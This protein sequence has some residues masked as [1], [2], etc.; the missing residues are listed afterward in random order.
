M[1]VLTILKPLFWVCVCVQA[2][3]PCFCSVYFDT[4]LRPRACVCVCLH[5]CS[6]L[7]VLF[8]FWLLLTPSSDHVHA[9]VCLHL[10]SGS[11]A[12]PSA[13]GF[14]FSSGPAP[15]PGECMPRWVSSVYC[16]FIC[17]LPVWV[18]VCLSMCLCACVCVSVCV[19]V[20]VCVCVC[21]QTCVS[22]YVYICY[23]AVCCNSQHCFKGAGH[24]RPSHL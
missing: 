7:S 17:T 23:C 18:S 4:F 1:H 15:A 21:V 19:R 22:V 16:V 12:A 6:G 9:C 11:S 8:L 20:C 10:C 5:L 2:R 24:A 14:S 3:Q 13:P